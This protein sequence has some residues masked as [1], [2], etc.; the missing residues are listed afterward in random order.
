MSE[1]FYLG[2][3]DGSDGKGS[4]CNARDPASIP[5]LGRSPGEGHGNPLQHSCL[6]NSM[7]RGAWRATVH[8]VTKSWIRLSD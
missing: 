6:E 7:D 3:T 8:G 2:F 5:R 1:G 4:A